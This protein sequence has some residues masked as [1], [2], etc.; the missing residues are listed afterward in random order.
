LE[1]ES[2][3]KTFLKKNEKDAWVH[4]TAKNCNSRHS[5]QFNW[6]LLPDYSLFILKDKNLREI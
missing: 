5:F 3:S 4:T 1:S 6:F 2:W